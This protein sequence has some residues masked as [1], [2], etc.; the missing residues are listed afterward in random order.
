[1]RRKCFHP[2]RWVGLRSAHPGANSTDLGSA[3]R[4]PHG[5]EELLDLCPCP[6]GFSE[7]FQARLQRR[8]AGETTDIDPFSQLAPAVM[9]HKAVHDI[10]Q[11]LAVEWVIGLVIRHQPG[12]LLFS[13]NHVQRGTGEECV[14]NPR[15]AVPSRRSMEHSP[16]LP[17]R[18]GLPLSF[19]RALSP[20][21]KGGSVFV[22]PI[23]AFFGPP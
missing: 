4:R 12:F 11:R 6:W 10:L 18:R 8:I 16:P 2:I 3:L 5:D 22:A 19:G 13:A 7:E 9:R 20:I 21:D 23:I 1:M 17:G 14:M 15:A